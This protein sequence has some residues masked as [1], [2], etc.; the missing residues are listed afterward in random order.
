MLQSHEDGT[1]F[2]LVLPDSQMPEMMGPEAIRAERTVGYQGLVVGLT[3][4]ALEAAVL[5]FK[6]AG[7]NDF[8]IEPLHLASI[9][10]LLAAMFK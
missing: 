10:G 2:D 9:E 7:T 3:G 1:A 6:S 8:L 5:H 4:N